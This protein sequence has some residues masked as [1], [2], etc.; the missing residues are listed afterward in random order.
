MSLIHRG[1]FPSVLP[2]G[3]IADLGVSDPSCAASEPETGTFVVGS[4]TGEVVVFTAEGRRRASFRANPQGVRMLALRGGSLAVGMFDAVDLWD[5]SETPVHRWRHAT[6]SRDYLESVSL[7]DSVVSVRTSSG[8]E[9]LLSLDGSPVRRNKDKQ[10]S[11][12]DDLV[13]AWETFEEN[14]ADG[15]GEGAQDTEVWEVLCGLCD[16]VWSGQ[17]VRVPSSPD[18]WRLYNKTSRAKRIA[19]D[20]AKAA[21]SIVDALGRARAGDPDAGRTFYTRYL[22]TVP[23]GGSEAATPAAFE[24]LRLTVVPLP[25]MRAVTVGYL[26]GA[27]LW[28]LREVSGPVPAHPSFDLIGFSPSGGLLAVL[29]RFPDGCERITT[30]DCASLEQRFTTDDLGTGDNRAAFVEGDHLVHARLESV[31]VW[32]A[33]GTECHHRDLPNGELPSLPGRQVGFGLQDGSIR[34]VDVLDRSEGHLSATPVRPTID[35]WAASRWQVDA[36]HRVVTWSGKRGRAK[37]TFVVDQRAPHDL[38]GHHPSTACEVRISP[39]AMFFVV[40][41]LCVLDRSGQR[42]TKT[43][44]GVMG[45]AHLVGDEVIVAMR[46]PTDAASPVGLWACGLDATR[47]CPFPLFDANAVYTTAGG[48]VFAHLSLEDGPALAMLDP[49]QW[50]LIAS[51]S[52]DIHPHRIAAHPSGQV[53]LLTRGGSTVQFYRFEL[54]L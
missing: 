46:D 2:R 48:S 52:L 21:Q 7:S 32:S 33:D 53:A 54:D 39:R 27:H 18:E 20:L 10:S 17:P 43:I 51:I 15:H 4:N 34:W 5:I 1:V 36:E 29:G 31:R 44:P 23:E 8:K 14:R 3:V 38:L 41:E 26:D 30:I 13:V 12:L 37:G 16:Q 42:P 49:I 6:K 40:D 24:N 45:S 9:T 47:P 25:N 11:I 50:R 28:N 22:N 35:Y 19:A